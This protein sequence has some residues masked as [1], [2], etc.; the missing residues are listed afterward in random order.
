MSQG[1]T[2]FG[3]SIL[4]ALFTAQ[5]ELLSVLFRY[6]V[7]WRMH[8]ENWPTATE[9]EDA[10]ILRSAV[11][12][13][14]N[15]YF[16][17]FFIA[18]AANRIPWAPHLRCPGWQCMPVLQGTF[19][20]MMVFSV[21]Y[22]LFKDKAL[23]VA[24]KWWRINNPGAKLERKALGKVV[25]LAMEEQLDMA[26]ARDIVEYYEDIVVQFGFI[27]MF[28]SCFPLVGVL[29]LGMHVIYLRTHAVDLL[30]S[31]QRAPYQCASDI[32]AWQQVLNVIAFMAVITNAGLCGLTGHA[33]YFYKPDLSYVDRLWMVAIL[34][35]VMLAAKILVEN[36]MS[37]CPTGAADE[38]QVKQDKK[39]ALLLSLDIK[40]D[41][42]KTE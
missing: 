24:L 16:G 32:G 1:D 29:A 22:R 9:R 2:T 17:I 36:L 30:Q 6:L 18:F 19:T 20:S 10:M 7:N 26:P 40:E 5:S 37:A 35:H 28:A 41:H 27:A 25:L 38:Y 21:V 13:L 8:L 15:A 3:A 12:K 4:G 34:E 39:E 23:P 31:T 42:A 14:F 33:I 11:F